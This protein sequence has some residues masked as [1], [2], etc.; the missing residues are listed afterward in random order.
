MS[1]LKKPKY[2]MIDG[3]DG[4][5]KTTLINRLKEE[6]PDFVYVKEPGDERF[7]STRKIREIVLHSKEDIPQEAELYLFLADRIILFDFIKKQLKQGKTVI[8]DRSFCASV[9]YQSNQN[10]SAGDVLNIYSAYLNKALPHIDNIVLLKIDKDEQ[11]K[12][13][14]SRG[15]DLDRMEQKGDDFTNQVIHNYNNLCFMVNALHC[16]NIH[17]KT[18]IDYSNLADKIHYLNA[19]QSANDVYREFKAKFL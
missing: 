13:L 11:K 8:S 9:A 10:M 15:Q 3:P 18:S 14:F 7:E 17:Q 12:R 19:N 4:C 2:I 5:G 1:Y 16:S 6:Y